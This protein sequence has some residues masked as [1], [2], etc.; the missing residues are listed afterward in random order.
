VKRSKKAELKIA[1]FRFEEIRSKNSEGRSKKAEL[2][3]EK[4]AI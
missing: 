1:D 4:S 3:I 2:K